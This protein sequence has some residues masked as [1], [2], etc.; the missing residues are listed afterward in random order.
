MHAHTHTT[1]TQ[2]TAAPKIP[3]LLGAR[4]QWINKPVSGEREE[5]EGKGGVAVV[6]FHGKRKGNKLST[7][8]RERN[9]TRTHPHFRGLTPKSQ[10]ISALHRSLHFSQGTQQKRIRNIT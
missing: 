7:R 10:V 3:F 9:A 4:L 2:Q 8:G 6:A 5:G 1:S